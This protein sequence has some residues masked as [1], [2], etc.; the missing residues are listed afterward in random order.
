MVS[1]ASRLEVR[2]ALLDIDDRI[3]RG[4]VLQRIAA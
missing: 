4:E 2:R 3:A 1:N